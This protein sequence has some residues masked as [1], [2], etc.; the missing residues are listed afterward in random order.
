[1]FLYKLLTFGA[2][3]KFWES[4]G[5][6][7]FLIGLIL[8]IASYYAKIDVNPEEAVKQAKDFL[9]IFSTISA[10]L[11]IVSLFFKRD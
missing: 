9:A 7:V 5:F 4:K 8:A 10:F 11:R 2:N 1:M 6:W 3:K